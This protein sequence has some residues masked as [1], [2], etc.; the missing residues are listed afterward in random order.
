[1]IS[2]EPGLNQPEQESGMSSVPV[3]AGI[4]RGLVRREEV[5]LGD[6]DEAKRA[7]ARRLR[8]GS[9]SPSNLL[10]LRLKSMKTDVSRRIIAV[11]I[12]DLQREI[13]GLEHELFVLLEMDTDPLAGDVLAA[14]AALETART[15]MARLKVSP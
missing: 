3:M 8:L 6:L 7:V 12:A 10:R 11:A 4:A 2:H 14:Q 1:M 5:R 15:A 13:R 9:G